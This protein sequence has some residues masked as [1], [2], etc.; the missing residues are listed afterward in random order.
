LNTAYFSFYMGSQFTAAT[1]SGDT[2]LRT[3]SPCA[4]ASP[5]KVHIIIMILGPPPRRRPCPV[6]LPNNKVQSGR[7]V[8]EFRTFLL[9]LRFK[10]E[11]EQLW[12]GGAL[13][14]G[15]VGG[16]LGVGILY[17][18]RNSI[19][20][21]HLGCFGAPGAAGGSGRA[22][23]NASQLSGFPIRQAVPVGLWARFCSWARW[24]RF[25][26]EKKMYCGRH[27]V[28]TYNLLFYKLVSRREWMDGVELVRMTTSKLGR[29]SQLGLVG[30][31]F[32]PWA[33]WAR[34]FHV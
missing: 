8:S 18:G 9:Y 17:L 16:E 25:F 31:G 33:R 1:P 29:R 3:L 28:F 30:L 32:A 34:F 5:I 22:C 23:G 4:A 27:S 21:A 6:W 20:Y 26:I 24:A 7:K 14:V 15:L 13:A 10:A 2:D 12:S 11:S 19:L